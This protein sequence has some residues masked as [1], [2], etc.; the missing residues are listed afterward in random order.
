MRSDPGPRGELQPGA[1][2]TGGAVR[3][4]ATP[5]GEL[6]LRAAHGA[7]VAR[8]W[9]PSSDL[10]AFALYY[11]SARWDRV[12]RAPFDQEV[13]TQPFVQLVFERDDVAGTTASR[14]VGVNRRRF[15]RRLEGAGRVVGVALQP[16]ALFAWLGLPASRLT[17]RATPLAPLLGRET[18]ALE[19]S[20][21][22]AADEREQVER[23]ERFL[24]PHARPPDGAA[25]TVRR[26][27]ARIT[28]DPDLRT[29][30][31]LVAA[32]GVGARELQRLFG[33]LVGASPK[34]VLRRHRL[35]EA[36]RL[37]EAGEALPLAALG[38]ALGYF[39]QAHFIRDFKAT[40]GR[41]PG[42]YAREAAAAGARGAG[43]SA[44]PPV[45]RRRRA[46]V[47]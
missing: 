11:W 29:A 24:R 1:T 27:F 4:D 8:R 9:L 37:L 13:L 22:G 26:L 47:K 28:S 40:V 34:W 25:T 19:A 45:P 32:S 36:A 6:K 12:G 44:E 7:Y 39:D 30:E 14:V 46:S 3:T 15:T 31:E 5:R 21:L 23:I 42:S 41:T 43:S 18:G 2:R 20:L 10:D 35:I 16:G 33:R 17:D 38:A